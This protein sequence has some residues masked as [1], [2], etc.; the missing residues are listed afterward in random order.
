M[1]D[2]PLEAAK[3]ILQHETIKMDIGEIDQAG[4]AKYFMNIAALGQ[5]IPKATA[6]S[7]SKSCSI[8]SLSKN[9]IFLME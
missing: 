5:T 9:H 7:W 8:K 3:V 2:E 4:Q 1:R 6:T